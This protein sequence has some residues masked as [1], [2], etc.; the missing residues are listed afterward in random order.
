MDNSLVP[1]SRYHE[2]DTRMN[3]YEFDFLTHEETDR[4]YPDLDQIKTNALAVACLM[5]VGYGIVKRGDGYAISAAVPPLKEKVYNLEDSKK[6][7]FQSKLAKHEKFRSDLTPGF[8]TAFLISKNK[9]LTAGHC[10]PANLQIGNIRVVFG[11]HKTEHDRDKKF[12]KNDSVYKIKRVLL[13]SYEEGSSKP[14]YA[15]LKLDRIVEGIQPIQ[16]MT[17]EECPFNLLGRSI[18]TIG[19]PTGTAV[20]CAGIGYSTIKYEKLDKLDSDL[21]TLKGNSGGPIIDRATNKAIGI[22]IRGRDDYILG[23]PGNKKG[24]ITYRSNP[25]HVTEN[26]FKHSMGQR[27]TIELIKPDTAFCAQERMLRKSKSD[28]NSKIF[29]KEVNGKYNSKTREET[30]ISIGTAVML[31]PVISLSPYL[32]PVGV[33]ASYAAGKFT[34]K[35]EEREELHK[36][37]NQIC[38]SEKF[39][40]AHKKHKLN[41]QE[42][43]Q[44]HSDHNGNLEGLKQLSEGDLVRMAQIVENRIAYGLDKK[45][46]SKLFDIEYGLFGGK[47]SPE[48]VLDLI[49]FEKKY[50]F[51]MSTFHRKKLLTYLQKHERAPQNGPISVDA[52]LQGVE[53]AYAQVLVKELRK[54]DEFSDYLR[55]GLY[56]IAERYIESIK[57]GEKLSF[58]DFCNSC[59]YPELN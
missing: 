10:I 11:F 2:D 55:D 40:K 58:L 53:K 26:D 4:L 15:I 32:I 43:Y 39:A 42:A 52:R 18:Y 54:Q 5:R 12:F 49:L 25:D 47:F 24:V 6:N 21:D 37:D 27:I 1:L 23:L 14:D 7:Q 20:K 16:V 46:G 38:W 30:L 29:E 13:R 57:N 8:A 41:F 22:L 35:K 36:L 28:H 31:L 45:E 56:E 34:H 3:M 33:I 44:I 50:S 9:I 59:I 48:K 17:A 51:E 19:C